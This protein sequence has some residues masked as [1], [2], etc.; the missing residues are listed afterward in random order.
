MKNVL[1]KFLVFLFLTFVT[2]YGFSQYCDSLV[3]TMTVDLSA[4]PNLGWVSPSIQRD[5]SCCGSTAPDVCLEFVITLHADAIAIEFNIASGAVPPGALFYQVDCGPITPVGSPICLNGPGPHNLT[6][7]KPG[8]NQNT[9]SI[10][11]FAAPL[12]GPDITLNAG[13]QGFI[14]AEYYDETTI[15]WTSIWPGNAGDY[16]NLLSCTA[17]CDT[18][19]LIAPTSGPAY[20]DYVVCGNDI[21]GCNPNPI[22]DTIRVN[23]IE[24]VSVIL[25]NDTTVCADVPTVNL[26]S[27]ISGGS[28]PY[29]I[30]WSNGATSS[31]ISVAPG[32]YSA[33]VTDASGCFVASDTVVVNV[34]PLPNV[35]A[36]PDQVICQGPQVTLSASGAVSYVWDNSVVNGVPFIPNLGTTAYTVVGTDANGCVNSDIVNVTVNPLP[37]I[38]AIASNV[39]ICEGGSVTLT[40]SGGVGY[41]WDNAVVDGI[42]FI[43]PVGTTMYHVI[44]TDVNGCQNTDSISVISNPL[45]IVVAGVD[46]TICFGESAILSGSGA[47]TYAWSNGVVNGVAFAPAVGT[48]TYTVVGTDV[49]G[50]TNS[51]QVDVIVNPLPIII[52]N[53]T[54]TAVCD[55]QSA[56]LSG[57]GGVS[58]VWDNGVLDDVSFI[59]PSGVT[60]Y[61]VIGTDA[62][63]CIN[64]DQINLTVFTL[65]TVTAGF[66]QVVCDEVSVVLSG[67]G[68][69]SYAWNN[70][71]INNVLF[72]SPIGTTTYTVIGTDVNGCTNTDQVDVV[73]NALP[74]VGAGSNIS[75]CDLNG[76]ILSGTGASSY[77]WDN[78]VIND[79]SFMSP[80]GT[81]TYT[82][83][84]TDVNGCS[85]TDNVDVTTLALPSVIAGLDQE[86]CD[87]VSVV[88]NATGASSFIWSGGITNGIYFNQNVGQVEY[89]VTGTDANSCSNTDTVIVIVNPNP[90][91][92]AGVDQQVCE[93]TGITLFAAGSPALFWNNNVVNGVRFIQGIGTMA[94]IVTDILPTGCF[95][96]DTVAVTVHPNPIVSASDVE[97]CIGEGVELNGEG[98]MHYTWTGNVQDGI[99]F[100]PEQSS[101]Y[102]VTG[103]SSFGCSASAVAQVIVHQLPVAEFNITQLSLTTTAST[104]GFDNLSIGADAYSWDFG[105]FSADSYEFEPEHT[106][107]SEGSGSYTITLTATTLY[108]CEDTRVKYVHVFQDYTIYVPNTFTPDYNG[109]NEVFKPE[110]EGFDPYE[111]T[112]YIFNRWGDLIFESHNMEIGWDGSFKGQAYDSQDGVYTW[113]IEAGLKDSADSKI[114][115]GHVSILK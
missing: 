48:I 98:A 45:P 47:N 114:F 97:I 84:G 105:D 54:S 69:I 30:L 99:T 101:S 37:V 67:A 3:P 90:I 43:P 85:N 15:S 60:T 82:V 108:G 112:L 86:V 32:T 71:V 49:N 100:Y 111:Y 2:T 31:S 115:V 44:G 7:C 26:S 22:C 58:Y 68:A 76:V 64:T 39:V 93:G 78:G 5:G 61:T 66:D 50:C 1:N 77:V 40:G 56:A 65:P 81:T 23:F 107:P 27:T 25:S 79:I 19:Y 89:I 103:Y 96:S 74:N 24:P 72:N 55:G 13:C 6:F 8:N 42:S 14:Y 51:D 4:S 80:V 83:I 92:N 104:T 70:G 94:Y 16:D 10:T 73:V 33:Q 63:G 17:A 102:T 18:T 88:L 46:Q 41:V 38:Q 9:F 34:L 52:A 59:P 109:V 110:M 62:N 91:I 35:I 53:T 113:K 28:G 11:S 21:P 12:I 36:G 75:I 57:S 20:V 29:S 87:G 106:Y 95:D